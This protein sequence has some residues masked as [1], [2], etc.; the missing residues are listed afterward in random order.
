MKLK[1]EFDTYLADLAVITFKLHNLHWNV[2]G[3]QFKSIHEFTEDLYNQ[4]FEYFDEIAEH[5][6]MYGYLPENKLSSY[7][8]TTNIQETDQSS[9][10]A[11]E[12]LEILTSDLESLRK[13]ATD[14]R[15][16]ADAE[17]W[18]SAV[19]VFEDHVAY[20]N[21]QLWFIKEMLG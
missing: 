16:A 4:T 10:T 6:K 8:A 1:K 9:F 5:E 20:Y 19:S 11:T 2:K 15:N 17:G 14:L 3:L 18:F 7:L 21:K 12:V 13:E